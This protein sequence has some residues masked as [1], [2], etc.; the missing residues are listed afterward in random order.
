MNGLYI[1]KNPK[2]GGRKSIGNEVKR[3]KG[4]ES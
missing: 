4:Y 2:K 3:F 1:I